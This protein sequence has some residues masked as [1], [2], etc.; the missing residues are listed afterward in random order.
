MQLSEN[1]DEEDIDVCVPIAFFFK[2]LLREQ[3]NTNNSAVV[4]LNMGLYSA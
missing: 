4:N 3:I 2:T 1:T